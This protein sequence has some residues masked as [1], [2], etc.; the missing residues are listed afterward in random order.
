MSRDLSVMMLTWEFPPRIIGGIS[1]HVYNLSKS[2]ASNGVKA[3]V[4][5]CDFPGAPQHESI[6]GVEVFRIDSYKN[7]APDFATWVYLMNVNMQKEAAALAHS[8]G[9]KIDVFHAH[10]WLVATAGIGLKHVFRKPFFATIHS[11]EIGRRNGIH[12]DYERM[13]HDTE[14]WLTYEAWKVICCSDY[15]VSHVRWA[16][17]LPADKL[18]MVPNGV[19]IEVY[20][21]AEKD[22]LSQFRNR[23]AL[24]QEKIVLFVGRL[25]YEKGVHVLVNAVPKVLAKVNAKF[26]I[27]GNGY[28]RDQLANVVKGMGLT[29]KVLFTGFLDDETLRKL[30][31]C[32][33][34]S[35]VPSLFEPFGIVALEAM[36]AKSPVVVSDT[37]GLSEI[38]NHDVDGVKVYT[39]NPDSLAWG[40]TRVLADEAYANKLRAN[41]YKRVLEKYNWNKIAQ[42]TKSIYEAVLSEYSKSFWAVRS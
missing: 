11:T 37:G 24:P 19:N 30:Q 41:A 33:D 17:G 10:D 13:I 2:L 38:V 34:V 7:P 20:E 42:Q 9:G 26:I 15:M 1:P 40:I 3:Y 5:T 29:H 31:R 28:M 35:V 8:V 4:V 27:V 25:V 14:A 36:A 21:K 32:A 18:V 12:F 39:D 23:F 22:D 6:D 16:F